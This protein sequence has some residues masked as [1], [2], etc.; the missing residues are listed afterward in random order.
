MALLLGAP[1]AGLLADAGNIETQRRGLKDFLD[2][3][4]AV[5][6]LG[7]FAASHGTFRAAA[8]TG[9][10]GT[11][12]LLKLIEEVLATG[13]GI[14]ARGALAGILAGL[15]RFILGESAFALLLILLLILRRLTLSLRLALGLAL[16]LPLSL[17]SGLLAALALWSL[18]ALLLS[19]LL[20]LLTF[21]G[22]PV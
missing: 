16:A 9:A 11:G 20:P 3:A 5:G 19:L 18:L 2:V 8:G 22:L 10:R 7:E 17:L 12:R 14:A 15:L 21:L 1:R 13:L 6:P 4:E